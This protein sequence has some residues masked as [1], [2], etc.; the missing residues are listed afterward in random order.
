MFT[1][2]FQT[3][4]LFKRD[5][6]E[7]I[8]SPVRSEYDGFSTFSDGRQSVP[9][10]P[11]CRGIHAR[12]RLVEEDNRGTPHEG[13]ADAKFSFIAS[14]KQFKYATVYHYRLV[15]YFIINS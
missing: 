14:A 6:F 5:Y 7:W 12:C 4:L 3:W 11:P 15:V 13:Y 9:E 2:L 1:T 10:V 8:I